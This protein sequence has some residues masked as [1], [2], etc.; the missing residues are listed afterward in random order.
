[1]RAGDVGEENGYFVGCDSENPAA[2]I[3]MM[4]EG[5]EEESNGSD[6][7]AGIVAGVLKKHKE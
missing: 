1:M 4:I 2:I 5:I 6:Y 7:V 3:A